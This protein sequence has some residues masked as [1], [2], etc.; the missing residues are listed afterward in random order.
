MA[1][2]VSTSIAHG[3]G[4]AVCRCAGVMALASYTGDYL[5]AHTGQVMTALSVNAASSQGEEEGDEARAG[6]EGR[7][8]RAN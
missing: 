6:D 8:R 1:M 2:R 4:G 7:R 3:F 5:A